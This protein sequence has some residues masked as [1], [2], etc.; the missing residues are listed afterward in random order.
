MNISKWFLTAIYNDDASALCDR[1][2]ELLDEWIKQFKK[3]WNLVCSPEDPDL[4]KCEITGFLAE[5]VTLEYVEI[6]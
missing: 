2:I 1:E 4:A 3:P 5:C 6:E